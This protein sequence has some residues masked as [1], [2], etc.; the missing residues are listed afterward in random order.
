M[1]ALSVGK[2]YVRQQL[3]L[4]NSRSTGLPASRGFLMVAPGRGIGTP[5]DV[6]GRRRSCGEGAHRCSAHSI[7]LALLLGDAGRPS[8]SSAEFKLLCIERDGSI[9]IIHDV[10]NLECG[11]FSKSSSLTE[12]HRICTVKQTWRTRP[13][14]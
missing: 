4:S 10:P 6:R 2:K 7:R 8:S 13:D 5:L 11:H 3:G 9:D 14:S 1:P 12:L